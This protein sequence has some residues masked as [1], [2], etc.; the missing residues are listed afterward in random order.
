MVICR[1]LRHGNTLWTFISCG[2]SR[3]SI[4]S[5]KAPNSLPLVLLKGFVDKEGVLLHLR[6]LGTVPV[7]REDKG[8]CELE[9]V[10]DT[11]LAEGADVGRVSSKRLGGCP[12]V[13]TGV[14]G[15]CHFLVLGPA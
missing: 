15:Q 6:F 9:D 2:G 5:R 7:S 1:S 8:D 10:G 12:L 13:V 3:A 11:G 4:S 14:N